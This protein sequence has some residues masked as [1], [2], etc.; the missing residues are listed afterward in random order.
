M[1]YCYINVSCQRMQVYIYY[2]PFVFICSYLFLNED[3]CILFH[4]VQYAYAMVS[5]QHSIISTIIMT[6][7]NPTVFRISFQ[8]KKNTKQIS[9]SQIEKTK[10]FISQTHTLSLHIH[11]V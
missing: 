2:E 3:I 1:S 6:I 11:A 9:M 5:K 4:H 7:Y 10:A 8:Y